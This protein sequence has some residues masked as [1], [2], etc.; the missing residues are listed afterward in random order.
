MGSQLNTRETLL[1]RLEAIGASLAGDEDALAL[2]SLGSVGQELDRLDEFSDLDFFVVV[3][4]GAKER[5]LSDLGWLDAV[6]PVAFSHR[7]TRD[8]L[9]ILFADRIYC[10]M[11]IFTVAEL[12][13]SHYTPGRL[14]WKRPG[15][16]ESLAEP[17][18]PPPA[19][20]PPAV[21][22]LLG[23]IVCNLYVGAQR[24][25]RGE[26]LAAAREVQW[27][28][29]DRMLEL[30]PHLEPEMTAH[31]DPFAPTRRFEQRFPQMAVHLAAFQPGYEGTLEAVRAMLDFLEP[32]VELNPAM[33]AAIREML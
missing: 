17:A 28:A 13:R 1:Q 31:P 25:R 30:A 7:G 24:Y 8:G 6:A 22:L 23:E 20:R 14:I 16:D 11:A 29:L 9:H 4:R 27:Y 19:P 10:E 26:R 5:F 32:R 33:V 2:L 21:T 3:R 15:V 12:G 18:T